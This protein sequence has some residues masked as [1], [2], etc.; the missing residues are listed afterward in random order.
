MRQ[1]IKAAVLLEQQQLIEILVQELVAV[2]IGK[3]VKVD[4]Q[5]VRHG[6]QRA[7]DH[8]ERMRADKI[9][10]IRCGVQL[11][12]LHARQNLNTAVPCR[13]ALF[14][15]LAR[16]G[17]RVTVVAR[18]ARTQKIQMIGNADDI[19][20]GLLAG[21]NFIVDGLRILGIG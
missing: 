19:Q 12:D 5:I 8:I 1:H 3:V 16:T 11:A 15:Y 14:P 17:F 2:H 9:V 18:A 20:S 7:D 4:I 10:R 21:V 6:M 13:T